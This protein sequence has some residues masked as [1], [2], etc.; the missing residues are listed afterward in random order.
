M[1]VNDQV[2]IDYTSTTIS[3][4]PPLGLQLHAF[5]IN[6]QCVNFLDSQSALSNM[7]ADGYLSMSTAK[8]S[9]LQQLFNDGGITRRVFALCF[10]D[11]QQQQQSQPAGTSAGTLW[12]GDIT[13]PN[14]FQT[15]LVYALNS[16]TQV[17]GTPSGYSVNVR[18]IYLAIGAQGDTLVRLTQNAVSL[19]P[20][21][22]TMNV[23]TVDFYA[24]VNGV[25]GTVELDHTKPYTLLH[26]DLLLPFTRAFLN[27]TGFPYNPA[28]IP[29]TPMQ[30]KQ[31]PTIVL[32]L[33]VRNRQGGV[34]V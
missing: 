23:P 32:Q 29:M 7:V 21:E 17:D 25:S 24:H 30:F 6:F 33:E 19:L 22:T 4:T 13:D 16:A 12:L 8:T 15:P 27:V 34:H 28:G 20:I 31:L 1:E 2:M 18:R 14:R 26:R 9:F 5:H 11:L 10:R 3:A